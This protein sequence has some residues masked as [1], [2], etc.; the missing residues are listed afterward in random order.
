MKLMHRVFSDRG[1]LLATV[2]CL[3]ISAALC[4]LGIVNA[5][6]EAPIELT[7]AQAHSLSTYVMAGIAGEISSTAGTLQSWGLFFGWVI[8]PFVAALMIAAKASLGAL[9]DEVDSAA[10]VY[11]G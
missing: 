9:E 2:L 7:T 10:M 1:I 6:H 5:A 3:M 8:T 4:M 11:A